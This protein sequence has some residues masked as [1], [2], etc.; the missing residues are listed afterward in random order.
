MTVR[1]R[2]LLIAVWDPINLIAI[3]CLANL[4]EERVHFITLGI[5]VEDEKKKSLLHHLLRLHL[6]QTTQMS[7]LIEYT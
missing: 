2:V 4:L 6:L 7:S 3:L 1:L 5:V